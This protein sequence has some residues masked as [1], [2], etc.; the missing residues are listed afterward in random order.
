MNARTGQ[1]PAPNPADHGCLQFKS[2]ERDIAVNSERLV[3]LVMVAYSESW[4]HYVA[5]CSNFHRLP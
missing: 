2:T 4:I 1:R 5:I 3:G